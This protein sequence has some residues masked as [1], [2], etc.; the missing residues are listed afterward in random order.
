MFDPR[1]G[2]PYFFHPESG[3]VTWRQPDYFTDVSPD[4]I[5]EEGTAADPQATPQEIVEPIVEV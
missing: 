5:D 2:K 3:E 4:E 1:S